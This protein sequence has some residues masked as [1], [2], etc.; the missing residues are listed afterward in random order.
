MAAP[1]VT[2]LAAMIYAYQENIYPAQVKE[3]ILNTLLPLN[4]LDGFLIYPGIPDAEAAI[5]SLTQL[6]TDTAK[7]FLILDTAFQKESISIRADAY[8]AGGSGVRK[9]R[10]SYGSKPAE[11]FITDGGTAVLDNTI[12]LTKPGYYTF[13]VEDYAGNYNLY[14]YYVEDDTLAPDYTASYRVAP[15]YSEITVYFSAFDS[16]SG[17][18]TIK[19]LAGEFQSKDFLSAG[20]ILDPTIKQHTI[21]V[22]PEI[23][24]LTFYLV[25][26]RGNSA[27]YVIHPEII[28]ATALHLNVSERS[29]SFLETFQLQPLIFPWLSN[30]GVTYAS[31]NNAVA[32]VDNDGLITAVG[33]GETLILVTT[34]SGI[35]AFCRILVPGLDIPDETE[36][37]AD[38]TEATSSAS[39]SALY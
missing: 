33:E 18:K 8:D 23:T 31:L 32:I 29:L 9:I 38:D 3:L 1:H 30:D 10:Y 26:Y 5:R 17:V 15:D 20:E 2:G 7:P 25:D 34:H 28:P 21:S 24:A 12:L 35:S 4:S 11:H 14:N 37:P 13:Y 19:Y 27:I 16:D 39:G 6:Q 36:L 22:T